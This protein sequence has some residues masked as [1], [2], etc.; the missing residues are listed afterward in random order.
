[1]AYVSTIGLPA[2]L[3]TSICQLQI[4]LVKWEVIFAIMLAKLL[5]IAVGGAFS[6]AATRR[7]DVT[8]FAYTLGGATALL[9]TMSD[10]MGIGF[11]ILLSFSQVSSMAELLLARSLLTRSFYPSDA[12]TAFH[13]RACLSAR[14]AQDMGDQQRYGRLLHLIILSALQS[15]LINPLAFLLLGLGRARS[16]ESRHG[17][18]TSSIRRIL[19]Q[20]LK[21]FRRNMMVM[22]V[23]TGTAYNLLT[24]AAPLPWWLYIPVDVAG[25]AFSP[26]VLVIG[27][28]SLSYSMDHLTSLRLAVL[29]TILVVLKSIILPSLALHLLLL[30]EPQSAK[31]AG[32]GG[33]A[34]VDFVFFYGVLPVA[35]SSL[36]IMQAYRVDSELLA[37]LSSSLALGKAV[38]FT[39][40]LL[41][42]YVITFGDVMLMTSVSVLSV[43]MHSLS[44]LG[45]SY[46]LF[47]AIMDVKHRAVARRSLLVCAGLQAAY[48]ASFLCSRVFVPSTSTPTQTLPHGIFEL[49]FAVVSTFRWGCHGWI[50]AMCYDQY[51]RTVRSDGHSHDMSCIDGLPSTHTGSPSPSI[52]RP[53]RSSLPVN[54]CSDGSSSTVTSIVATDG[55]GTRSGEQGS[56]LGVGVRRFSDPWRLAPPILR[57]HYLADISE[58]ASGGPVGLSLWGHA[59]MA[60]SYS[61][62]M[63]VPFLFRDPLYADSIRPS[64]KGPQPVDAALW[65]PYASQTGQDELYV[66]AYVGSALLLAILLSHI[67]GAARSS[68]EA[69]SSTDDDSNDSDEDAFAA[70]V[71]VKTCHGRSAGNGGESRAVSALPTAGTWGGNVRCRWDGGS[72]AAAQATPAQNEALSS[73]EARPATCASSCGDCSGSGPLV[74]ISALA[75]TRSRGAGGRSRADSDGS[76]REE[77]GGGADETEGGAAAGLGKDTKQRSSPIPASDSFIKPRGVVTLH[78]RIQL[79]AVLLLLRCICSA[80]TLFNL[81]L[82]VNHLSVPCGLTQTPPPEH[83]ALSLGEDGHRTPSHRPLLSAGEERTIVS[84]SLLFYLFIFFEDGQGFLTFLLF[85]LHLSPLRSLLPHAL[86]PWRSFLS[87][88]SRRGKQQQEGG[89]PAHIPTGRRERDGSLPPGHACGSARPL[90]PRIDSLE[91][92]NS[93]FMLS[94]LRHL[95]VPPRQQQLCRE[96]AD[97]CTGSQWAGRAKAAAPKDHMGS[98]RPTPA[99]LL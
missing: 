66:A 34:Y 12:C 6:W 2:L 18:E 70:A 11:P 9:A 94:N 40:L 54:V 68:P 71:A 25:Q 37:S 90:I 47:C 48:S 73:D 88:G 65:A 52:M 96:D 23:L 76:V 10:D 26:L 13:P 51:K 95:G 45:C 92:P 98:R 42:A 41:A 15:A 57:S 59:A 78:V 31:D 62:L 27:G 22:A 82:G 14:R 56:E 80:A 84:S 79:L 87:R 93:P 32:R 86:L 83:R 67:L 50:L 24:E 46:M 1:M 53:R 91:G 20:V 75:L 7:D 29:P 21:G 49:L 28:M 43:A 85:G 33:D 36:A 4:T 99:S 74:R 44:V 61:L 55:G 63:T 8:G 39:L 97:Q 69:H 5:L 64:C 60:G 17:L 38:A 58:P 72:S 81:F 19:V 3:F 89:S 16:E 77:H 30:L 35:T